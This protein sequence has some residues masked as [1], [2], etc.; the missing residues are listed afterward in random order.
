MVLIP[1]VA[2]RCIDRD[3]Q[4]VLSGETLAGL[5]QAG[6]RLD[7][8]AS[9]GGEHFEQEWQFIVE[10]IGHGLAQHAGGIQV[11]LVGQRQPFVSYQYL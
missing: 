9:R 11:D 1:V 5:L 6:M 10:T 2:M 8:Q 4:L 7:G 3:A